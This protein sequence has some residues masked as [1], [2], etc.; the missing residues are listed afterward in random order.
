M[1]CCIRYVSILISTTQQFRRMPLVKRGRCGFTAFLRRPRSRVCC[2]PYV[3]FGLTYAAWDL[4]GL[5]ILIFSIGGVS[6][7]TVCIDLKP[8]Y[9]ERPGSSC[10]TKLF[11][12]WEGLACRIGNWLAAELR[13][14]STI[15]YYSRFE[16]KERHFNLFRFHTFFTR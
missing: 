8:G 1:R 4:P 7:K 3:T 2:Q 10:Y 6:L 12:K 9:I 11:S 14:A 5:D 13:P 15:P 16:T